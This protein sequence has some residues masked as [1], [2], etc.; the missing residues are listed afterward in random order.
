MESEI[1]FQCDKTFGHFVALIE[2]KLPAIMLKGLCIH[3]SD[4]RLSCQVTDVYT[5]GRTGGWPG[6]E[7]APH[8]RLLQSQRTCGPVIAVWIGSP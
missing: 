3:P 2:G 8:R 5:C 1:F 6:R 4:L 7:D